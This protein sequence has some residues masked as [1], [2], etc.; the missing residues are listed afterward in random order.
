ME[1]GVSAGRNSVDEDMGV[2]TEKPE[3]SGAFMGDA[4]NSQHSLRTQLSHHHPGE[5]S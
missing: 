2:E 3:P 4:V 5:L 1:M